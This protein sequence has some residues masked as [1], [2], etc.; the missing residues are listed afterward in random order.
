MPA[1]TIN[2]IVTQDFNITTTMAFVDPFRV[3]NY[4]NGAPLY[5][6]EFLSEH[7]GH[8]RSSNGAILETTAVQA[9]NAPAD[10]TIVSASWTPEAHVSATMKAHLRAAKSKKQTIGALDTGAFILARCGLLE[11]YQATVHYEHI[12]AFQE[13][14]PNIT[15]SIAVDN[16]PQVRCNAISPGWIMA[17]MATDG[18]ALANDQECAMHDAIARHPVGRMGKPEDIANAVLWLASD[19]SQ[20]VNG[21]CI[22]VDGGMTAASPLNPGLF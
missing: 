2:L 18:F 9:V 12:D 6:W 1:E 19:Q 15:V 8:L 7:G 3:A 16:G 20:Y 13:L 21:A 14:F 17:E 10:Y 11:R 22:T 5:R 4:I